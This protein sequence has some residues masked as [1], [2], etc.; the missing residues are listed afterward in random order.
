[1]DKL[2]KSAFSEIDFEH[3]FDLSPDL[4]FILDRDHNIIRANQAMGERVG[5]SSESLVGSKCFWCMHQTDELPAFCVH[6]QVLKDGKEHRAE[7]FI[8]HLDGWFFVTATPLL[9]KDG[10][11]IGAI[12]IA[13]DFS[14][15]KRDEEALRESKAK[16]QAIFE[17]TG[18]A[19]LIVEEDTTIQMANKECYSV[20][21]YTP[22]EL[23]GQ[24]WTQFVA[25]ESLQEM[26][27]NHHLRRQNPDL[28]P[29]KYEVKLVNKKGDRRDALLDIGIIPDTK[30]SVVS[31]LDITE[32]SQMEDMLRESEEKYRT[33]FQES[34]S[35]ILIADGETKGFLFSN[36]AI[37]QMFGY[38]E[39]EFKLLSVKNIHPRDSLDS[40]I[41]A[42]ESQ[43]KGEISV[44]YALPCLRK[45]GTIFYAD[46]STASAIINGQKCAVG[47]FTDVT[48]RIK[49][50]EKLISNEQRLSTIYDTVGAIIFHLAVEAKGKY[51]FSSVNQA[52]C[53]TT[54]LSKGQ[55]VGKMVSEVISEPSL[56]MV[57]GKYQQAIDESTIVRWEETSDYPTGRLTGEVSIAPI[58][59]VN[60]HCTN[61]VGSVLDITDRKQAEEEI[62]QKNEELQLVNA[63][64]DKFFSIIAHDLR[65]PFNSFLGLTQIM[66]EQLPTMT[67]EKIQTIAVSMRKSATNLYGL[68]ENLLEWSRM[69]QGMTTFDPESFSLM[70]KI[71]G[72]LASYL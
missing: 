2:N 42:F 48:E 70:P 43:M 5:V 22:D 72:G 12:H 64:K 61:L 67:L 66:A 65:S 3:I 47:F 35:G 34:S 9:D 46:I 4:I 30:Q 20:T 11:I 25:P 71:S 38:S 8:E 49:I 16:Y 1:M 59:D 14:D 31:I 28:A 53:N 44:A 7:I 27:K 69:Q 45:D 63:E 26:M 21:G 60:G 58:F 68:L 41:S 62:K 32:R 56:M 50:E 36:P 19:T 39:E 40:V 18:A 6:S 37:C 23:I 33:I 55:I 15:R 17:S 24:K 52:F 54:G 29:K 51:R 13:R 10:A 57:L